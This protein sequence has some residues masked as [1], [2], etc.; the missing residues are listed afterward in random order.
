MLTATKPDSRASSRTSDASTPRSLDER[1]IKQSCILIVDDEQLNIEVVGRYLEIGGYR[2]LISTDHAGQALPLIGINRP[3]VVLLDI[4]MPEI[5]GLEILAAIRS[6]EALCRTPVLILT[7]SSDP[8]TKLIALKAGATDLLQKPVHGEELLARLGNVLKV[9][10]YQDQLYR[11]S[12]D[13]E[14]AV[15]RRTAELEASRLDVIHCLAR[16]AEFRDDDTGQHIIRVGRYARLIAE[17]LGFSQR[18]LDILEP[19]AQLHDV[20]KIGIT[21]TILLKP[22]KLTPEEYEMMQ[23]HCGYGRKIVQQLPDSESMLL[24][25]HTDIGARIMDASS[26]PILEM[27]RRIALTHHE[28]WDGNGYPLGL[29]GDDIPLE[30]RITAV[31]DVYDALS[32]KRP[33]KPPFPLQKCFTIM[34]EG[35]GTQFDPRVLDAFSE[36]RDDIIRVQIESADTD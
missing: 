28:R 5:N 8:E 32:S 21:D 36:R 9:K 4:H 19:A 33:Y 24:R 23:K 17:Q 26:S 2:N 12:E 27:A 15:Q 22:G 35:R 11:H 18:E 7:G 34:E 31:A 6:D 30:G 25:K 16:A 13:L 10:A 3:D 1:D 29:A 20:G 14:A